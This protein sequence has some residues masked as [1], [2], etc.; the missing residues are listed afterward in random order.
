LQAGSGEKALVDTESSEADQ[1]NQPAASGDTVASNDD[2]EMKAS[3]ALGHGHTVENDL[4]KPSN[5]AVSSRPQS[6]VTLSASLNSEAPLMILLADNDA[7]TRRSTDGSSNTSD[8]GDSRSQRDDSHATTFVLRSAAADLRNEEDVSDDN[9]ENTDARDGR[10]KSEQSGIPHAADERQEIDE[11]QDIKERQD[12]EERQVESAKDDRPVIY[13]ATQSPDGVIEHTTK[14]SV[15]S[16]W[17][18]AFAGYAASLSGSPT[19]SYDGSSLTDFWA[20]YQMVP[21]DAWGLQ[22]GYY[23]PGSVYQSFS[24]ASSRVT[25]EQI[26]AAWAHWQATHQ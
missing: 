22:Y 7:E 6:P 16:S 8:H 23:V 19:G 3:F 17:S 2:E 11:R 18:E 12:M 1:P 9:D 20:S 26:R 14:A 25:P 21:S 13:Y 15:P 10:F 24:D 5:S 4:C